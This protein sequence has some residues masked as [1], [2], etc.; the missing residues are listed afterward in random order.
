MKLSNV[1]KN[2]KQVFF[3]KKKNSVV[4]EGGQS[5]DKRHD[6]RLLS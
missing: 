4:I 1:M 3:K 5:Q 6:K 2:F